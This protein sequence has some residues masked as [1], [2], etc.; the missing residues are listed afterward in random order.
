MHKSKSLHNFNI[1]IILRTNI[2]D[3]FFSFAL[4]SLMPRNETNINNR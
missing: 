4:G 1:D 3:I 2:L